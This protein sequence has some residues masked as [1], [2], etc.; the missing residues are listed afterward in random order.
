[1]KPEM[2]AF[3]DAYVGEADCNA[4]RAAQLAGI[5][6][7]AKAFTSVRV[8]REIERRL[9]HD[10]DIATPRELLRF[11]T[12]ALRRGGSIEVQM[13]AARMLIVHGESLLESSEHD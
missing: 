11:L 7:A 6:D 5:E 3:V 13:A 8:C 4:G 2:Q 12:A 10:P 9:E 1:M